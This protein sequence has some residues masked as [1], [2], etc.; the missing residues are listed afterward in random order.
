MVIEAADLIAM[1]FTTDTGKRWYVGDKLQPGLSPGNKQGFQ[2]EY[3][4]GT[5]HC[6]TGLILRDYGT[7]WF[8]LVQE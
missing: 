8:L 3:N 5:Q 7:G 4:D 1:G 2:A 6:H